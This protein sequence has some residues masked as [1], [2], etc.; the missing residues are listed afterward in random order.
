[1]ANSRIGIPFNSLFKNFSPKIRVAGMENKRNV[2]FSD[3]WE[4]DV[5]GIGE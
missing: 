3:I 1:M 4:V 5:I 2:Q